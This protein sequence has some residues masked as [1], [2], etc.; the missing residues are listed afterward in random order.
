[1]PIIDRT[2]SIHALAM[3]L[4]Q[5]GRM[6]ISRLLGSVPTTRGSYKAWIDL[7]ERSYF[8]RAELNAVARLL[9]EKGIVTD[10]H[11]QKTL[12]EEMR[13]YFEQL[14]KAWPEVAFDEQG[15]TIKDVAALHQRSKDE[16]WPP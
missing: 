4:R 10:A 14:A 16:G 13:H 5:V 15:F 1:M 8:M 3:K 2:R 9:I 7:L 11:W 12:E 6:Q